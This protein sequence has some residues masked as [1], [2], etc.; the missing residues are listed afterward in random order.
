MSR[1]SALATR[2]GAA[3]A[4][5]LLLAG[6]L[7]PASLAAPS[8]PPPEPEG[9]VSQGDLDASIRVWDVSENI[10]GLAAGRMTCVICWRRLPMKEWH[11]ETSDGGTLRT[12]L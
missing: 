8:G 7:A 6:G 5:A 3:A 2:S 4:V 1:R 9:G 10:I 11:M 12:A